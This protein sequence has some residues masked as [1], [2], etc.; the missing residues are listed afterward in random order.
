MPSPRSCCWPWPSGRQTRKR[1]SG[2][3]SANCRMVGNR[4]NGA[5]VLLRCDAGDAGMRARLDCHSLAPC[6][7]AVS[8]S[9]RVPGSRVAR[10]L[11]RSLLALAARRQQ[12]SFSPNTLGSRISRR[13]TEA[14][15]RRQ[16]G[17]RARPNRSRRILAER[18][19]GPF[20]AGCRR[21][22]RS[23]DGAASGCRR[24]APADTVVRRV[25]RRRSCGADERSD[26]ALDVSGDLCRS[27]GGR[28][29]CDSNAHSSGEPGAERLC[30]RCRGRPVDRGAGV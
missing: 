14:S 28:G 16:A 21:T 13:A 24:P 17:S 12:R 18:N 20:L 9:R 22:A 29:R 6:G 8:S 1:A 2:G 27:G 3:A 15:P 7:N 30:S 4:C 5:V 19:T 23:S 25:V 10:L 11:R 26:R